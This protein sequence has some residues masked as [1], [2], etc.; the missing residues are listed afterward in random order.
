MVSDIV[1]ICAV[2]GACITLPV[3]ACIAVAGWYFV[4]CRQESDELLRQQLNDAEITNREQMRTQRAI[5]KAGGEAAPFDW[6]KLAEA[7]LPVLMQRGVTLNPNQV[8]TNGQEI[9]QGSGVGRP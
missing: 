7:F 2:I 8:K 3:M 6:G 9:Q 4:V 5:A 1:L